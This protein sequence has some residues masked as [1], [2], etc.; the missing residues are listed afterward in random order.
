M[1]FVDLNWL[2][3]D[4]W[5]GGCVLLISIDCRVTVCRRM[6][7]V[8]LNSLKGDSWEGGYILLISID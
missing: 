5:E 8:D 6:H 1:R 7:F 4:S 3:G 2:K